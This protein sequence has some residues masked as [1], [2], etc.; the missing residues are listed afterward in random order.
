MNHIEAAVAPLKADAIE[1]AA[2]AFDAH[3]ERVLAHMEAC[4][5]DLDVAYP[6][7]NSR[8]SRAEYMIAQGKHGFAASLTRAAKTSRSFNE[9]NIRYRADDRIAQARQGVQDAT[10]ASYDAFVA[11]LV[12]KVGDGVE[13]ADLDGNHVWGRSTLTVRKAAGKVERWKTQM[14]VNVSCLGKVF[15]QWP[16]RKVRH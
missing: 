8:M 2:K 14:I 1:R 13:A 9:P 11:K 12:G 4:G 7:A 10:A 16:S 5:W 6:R 3:V 15:N